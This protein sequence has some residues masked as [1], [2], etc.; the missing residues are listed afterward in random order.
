M[1]FS[2]LPISLFLSVAAA[3]TSTSSAAASGTSSVCA[4][5]DVLNQC[6]VTGRGYLDAC[7]S[8]DYA[9]LCQKSNDILTCYLQCP[10]DPG[11]SAA[12]NTKSTNCNNASIYGQTTTAISKA[13]SATASTSSASATGASATSDAVAVKTATGTASG[14]TSSA[15]G[16]A[17]S[18]GNMVIGAGSVMMGLAGVMAA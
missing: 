18:A 15:S 14:A 2:L 12:Q 9:C 1:Q 4:A 3:A 16:K 8:T 13:V 5:Q 7:A 11:Q 17:N 6:L 10:N